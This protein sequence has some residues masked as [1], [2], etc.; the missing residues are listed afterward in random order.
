MA[1]NP[2]APRIRRA[3][4]SMYGKLFI[5]FVGSNIIGMPNS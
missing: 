4:I 2:I 1:G 5:K 3:K